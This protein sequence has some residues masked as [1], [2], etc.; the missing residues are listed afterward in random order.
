MVN[1]AAQAPSTWLANLV[2]ADTSLVF[3]ADKPDLN[4]FNCC[5]PFKEIFR[6]WQNTYAKYSNPSH[7]L[8]AS[9]R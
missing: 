2:G 8:L 3:D 1:M 7:D 4:R 5:G 9:S 6:I